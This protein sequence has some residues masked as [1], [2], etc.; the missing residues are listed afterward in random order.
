ML[1]FTGKLSK[2]LEAFVMIISRTSLLL[3]MQEP[4]TSHSSFYTAR[5]CNA[6][7]VDQAVGRTW[8]SWGFLFF[9]AAGAAE[10]TLIIILPIIE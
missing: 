3:V 5:I 4:V 7:N 1:P 9:S 6:K 10:D 2:L 8:D